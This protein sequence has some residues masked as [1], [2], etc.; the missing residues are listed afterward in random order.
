M[1][2]RKILCAVDFSEPS[3]EALNT[4]AGLTAAPT[5]ELTLV[6]VLHS[7][8]RFSEVKLIQ[9]DLLEHERKQAETTLAS[10]KADA[11]SLGAKVVATK[12]LGGVPWKAIAD[13]VASNPSYD[14]LVM[15]THG[16][17]GIMHVLLGSV[18]ERVARH[19]DCPVLLVRRRTAR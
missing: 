10:W 14:L 19:A 1:R 4:A 2:F 9:S 7:P 16:R 6:H 13:E 15:G 11:E 18:A 3:R 5:A 17:T 8:V 12:V